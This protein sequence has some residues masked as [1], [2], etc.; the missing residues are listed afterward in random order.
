MAENET[1]SPFDKLIG[2]N[3]T[4]ELRLPNNEKRYFSGIISR[5]SEGTRGSVFTTYSAELVPK[6]WLL[7]RTARSRIFPMKLTVPEILEQVLS[8]ISP[9]FEWEGKFAPR[10]YCVQYHETD[11]NFASR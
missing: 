11:F 10:D 6:F 5:L 7:T 8:T 4:V 1:D 3:A 2:E 9:R